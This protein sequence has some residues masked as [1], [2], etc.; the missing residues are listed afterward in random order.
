MIYMSTAS[1]GLKG[2]CSSPSAAAAAVVSADIFGRSLEMHLRR[3]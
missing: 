1:A 2:D 3:V